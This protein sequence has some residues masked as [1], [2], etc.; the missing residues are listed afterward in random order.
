MAQKVRQNRRRI[1]KVKVALLEGCNKLYDNPLIIYGTWCVGDKV[2]H[3][4]TTQRLS[5]S[6][7]MVGRD[8]RYLFIK[9]LM[10]VFKCSIPEIV[11]A[12]QEIDNAATARVQIAGCK[13]C[14]TKALILHLKEVLEVRG[15]VAANKR[16]KIKIKLTISDNR[17][18]RRPLRVNKGSHMTNER[19]PIWFT[20]AITY[21]SKQAGLKVSEL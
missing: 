20:G 18:V 1:E 9:L 6:A 21:Q 15:R 19:P 2:H 14:N 4:A 16:L 17:T 10:E 12:V 5:L 8:N 7:V 3:E 11:T 13:L